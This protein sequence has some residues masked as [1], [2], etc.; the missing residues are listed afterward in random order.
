MAL[1]RIVLVTHS[2]MN[3]KVQDSFT[4][5]RLKDQIILC[6]LQELA[7]IRLA[8]NTILLTA[9]SIL[10]RI[11]KGKY[12]ANASSGLQLCEKFLRLALKGLHGYE[13]QCWTNT[14]SGNSYIGKLLDSQP[15]RT[16]LQ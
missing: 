14:N 16:H 1:S 9:Q 8:R 10:G 6:I 3:P 4:V 5:S 7:T 13:L 15:I 11:L 12:N 2:N